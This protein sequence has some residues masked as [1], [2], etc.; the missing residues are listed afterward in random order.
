MF[1][2][3]QLTADTT[4]ASTFPI[5]NLLRL[6]WLNG[7][8]CNCQLT[9][10]AAKTPSWAFFLGHKNPY[11]NLNVFCFS[12][13]L[14]ITCHWVCIQIEKKIMHCVY[15]I[16]Q[17]GLFIGSSCHAQK[18]NFLWSYNW[19]YIQFSK[20][21]CKKISRTIYFYITAYTP[22][23]AA[24]S[25]STLGPAELFT[26]SFKGKFVETGKDKR[27]RVN[28]KQSTFVKRKKKKAKHRICLFWFAG[29]PWD[30]NQ[31]VKIPS[32]QRGKLLRGLHS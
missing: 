25:K 15:I 31:S 13:E 21:N 30:I 26:G 5:S 22:Q 16:K 17:R 32:S 12:R 4:K 19:K 7:S 6:Y 18:E 8:E 10:T 11:T 29:S 9:S 2:V 14:T 23:F 20:A 3:K 1:P 24:T 28:K 27:E